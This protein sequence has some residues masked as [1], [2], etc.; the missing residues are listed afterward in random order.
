MR[1]L[2]TGT[3]GFIG[4]HLARRLLA[5]GH[6]VVGVDAMTAYYDVALKRRRLA[7][8]NQSPGFRQ[9][10]F[11]IE[12]GTRFEDLAGEAN[13]EIV[14]HLAAQA[15][16]RY[17]V[18]NPRAYIDANVVGTFNVLQACRAHPVRH[19]LLASTSSAYGANDAIPFRE[20]DR[21]VHPVSLYA[22]TKLAT[23][24]MAHAYSHLWSIPTTAFR[25]FTVYGPWGRPDL[26]PFLFVSKVLAGE[27]IDVFNDGKSERDFTYV[28]DLVEGIARLVPCIPP[29]P[30][31]EADPVPGDTLSPVAPFRVVNI[32][33]GRPVNLMDFVAAVE[34]ATGRTAERRYR[35]M[36]PGD[37]ER[38][39]ASTDLLEALTGYRPATPLRDG[40]AAFVAWY[41][42][43]YRV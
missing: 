10:E 28:D 2:V 25:F 19:L 3:A 43:H 41:R 26:A 11:A 29:R 27:P 4:F 21:A 17:S 42:E 9:H 12:D 18:E 15:G 22:A 40:I 24:H 31:D 23:E 35:P 5:E 30:G 8:L 37:V 14:V 1:V 16:V 34:A 13:P 6:E 39:F 38:T 33:G 36:P 32:G 7:V 20:T